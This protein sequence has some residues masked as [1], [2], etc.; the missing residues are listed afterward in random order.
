MRFLRHVRSFG[1]ELLILAGGLLFAILSRGR[2]ANVTEDHGFWF[3]AVQGLL[4]GGRAMHEVRLQ[5][6]PV[7][8]W[9]LEAA[10]RIFGTRVATIVVLQ[11][12][13]GLAGIV[14]VQVLSRSFLSPVER[15]L[16][17]AILVPLI[18]WIVGPGNLLYPC[19]FAMSHG[20]LLAVL[21]VLV[22]DA[23]VRRGLWKP[24]IIAGALAGVA[25]LT[26]QEFGVA[27]FAGILSV[28]FFSGTLSKGKKAVA[29]VIAAV[30]LA[31][32]YL[33]ILLLARHGDTLS[34]L[35]RSNLLW[36]W[37][38][39]PAPWR[40]LF[41]R[42]LGLDNPAA[43]LR[44]MT[45]SFLYVAAFGGTAWLAL[46]FRHVA[47]K[48]AVGAAVALAWLL[49]YWRWTE[50]G[51]FLPMT[52]VLPAIVCSTI[53]MIGHWQKVKPHPPTPSPGG[54]G[55]G[56]IAARSWRA[57]AS[58]QVTPAKAG[59]HPESDPLD[60]RVRGND[61]PPQ[62]MTS[63]LRAER[64]N[65]VGSS[66]PHGEGGRGVRFQDEGAFVALVLGALVLLQREGYRGGIEGYY[67]GMG[68]V[69]AIPVIAPLLWRLMRGMNVGGWRPVF[70]AILAAGLL[71]DF[72]VG[73]LRALDREWKSAIP[74]RTPRGTAYVRPDFASSVIGTTRFLEAHTRRE[75]PIL[76][77]PS[78]FG[79]D[80]LLDRRN[81]A[82]FPYVVPGYLTPEGERELIERCAK[83]PP[84]AAV[85]FEHTLGI[86]RSG[87]FEHGFADALIGWLKSNLP[88]RETFTY[89]GGQ[90][91]FRLWAR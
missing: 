58:I 32:S 44:E 47:R 57:P 60:S 21:T 43:R 16:S 40:Q 54:E 62:G 64:S 42:Y 17:A 30:G 29:M 51:H 68:Y 1:P 25:L 76:L 73:R 66:S 89:A 33:G 50:G 63:S 87:D 56:E 80:F 45:D 12:V 34:H 79:L 22:Q 10:C 36:P 41:W 65:L 59:V 23:F 91:G 74:L 46:Y 7:S 2:H 37:V 9:V 53:A 81:L 75:D 31:G 84:R 86:L 72:G 48:V 8:L 18:V 3:S 27:A 5:Y 15:W 70:A 71:F 39:V 85:I 35:V 88:E 24:S 90:A 49:W 77:L 28:I 55:E 83:T 4:S 19:A 67:S 69:L 82:F 6:G 38:P 61:N 26:K 20:L 78:T 14:G 13:V 11:F 52:L